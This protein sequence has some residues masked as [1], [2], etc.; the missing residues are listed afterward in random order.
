MKTKGYLLVAL[1]CL[2]FSML[3]QK[4]DTLKLSCPLNDASEPPPEKQPYSLGIPDVKIILT[5]PTDTTVKAVIAGTITNVMQDE[6][7]KWQIIFYNK[8]YYFW[9]SGISRSAVRKGQKLQNGQAIGYI[10]P[11]QKIELKV[12][13]F[14]TPL[15]P[16][17]YLDCWK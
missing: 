11:G 4:K 13:D 2:P 6:E 5:S 17:K 14:E 7:G 10:Q 8:D 12:Y 9:Y 16:K 1:F 3:A 15:D